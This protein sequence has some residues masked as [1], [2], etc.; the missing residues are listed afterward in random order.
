MSLVSVIIPVYNEE[1]NLDRMFEELRQTLASLPHEFE[2]LLVNDGSTDASRERL[3]AIGISDARVRVIEFTRNFGKEMALSAGLSA[4]RGDAAILLDADL[5]HPLAL[6]PRFLESWKEGSEVVVGVR[7]QEKERGWTKR[8]GAHMYY[9]IMRIVSETPPVPFSTDFRLLDRVV[10]DE[11][12]RFK[13]RY[14][15]TRAL[16]DWLGFRCTYIPFVAEERFGGAPT[17]TFRKLFHTAI[18]SMVAFSLF[19][20][21][22][23]GYMGIFITTLAGIF[24]SVI[25]V[26]K[27]LLRDPWRLHFT[28]TA[29]L[30]TIAIF[31]VGIILMCLGLISLYIAQIHAEAINRPLY[32][33][34]KK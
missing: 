19:P 24:A 10:I 8:L 22:L 15:M 2:I 20:L 26:E 18:S 13:E 12:C 32:V 33:I 5:Q 1:K 28:G 23:A 4:C 11:F 16:I 21:R 31:F 14:R 3:E 7:Q 25:F 27:Y 30:I 29:F 6:I 9:A 34:R 17:Y